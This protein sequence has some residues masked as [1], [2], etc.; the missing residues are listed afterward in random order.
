MRL[1]CNVMLG[2][3][4]PGLILIVGLAAADTSFAQ[5]N[6]WESKG[7]VRAGELSWPIPPVKPIDVERLGISVQGRST[8]EIA[9]RA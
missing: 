2:Y 3:I 8:E 9:A 1:L 6:P 7:R 5:T 4:G